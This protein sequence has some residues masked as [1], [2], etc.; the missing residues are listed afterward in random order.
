MSLILIE[1]MLEEQY[2]H[3]KYDERSNSKIVY[4]HIHDHSKDIMNI[5]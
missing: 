2:V 5:L 1:L 3:F 4:Y